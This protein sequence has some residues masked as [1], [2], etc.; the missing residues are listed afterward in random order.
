MADRLKGLWLAAP[1]SPYDFFYLIF[2]LALTL[3]VVFYPDYP[4][5][6]AALPHLP[7]FNAE[8]YTMTTCVLLL[9]LAW[10]RW[11]VPVKVVFL[12][13]PLLWTFIVIVFGLPAAGK[14]SDFV[15]AAVVVGWS[16]LFVRGGQQA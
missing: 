16:F 14:P 2:L 13:P 1:V 12:A 7:L 9:A 4:L 10:R 5:T 6:A 3:A 11:V 15:I 8:S